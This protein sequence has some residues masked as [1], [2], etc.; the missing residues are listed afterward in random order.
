MKKVGTKSIIPVYGNFRPLER[1]CN[2]K[3]ISGWKTETKTGEKLT[4]TDTYN[5][6]A[7]VVVKGNSIQISEWHKAEAQSTQSNPMINRVPEHGRK[8]EGWTAYQGASVT[9]TQNISVSEWGTDE[10]TRIQIT[11]GTDTTK[12]YY[13]ISAVIWGSPLSAG[14]KTQIL[15]DVKN[16][17]TA[18]VR[19]ACNLGNTATVN[20]G[21]TKSVTVNGTGNGSSHWMFSFQALS[22]S[23]N[24][25]FI[26]YN[27]RAY[28]LDEIPLPDNPFP[29]QT[30]IQAGTYKTQDHKGDWYEFS[31]RE[32]LHGYHNEKDIIE[33]DKYSRKGYIRKYTS[34][35]VFDGT[36]S[37]VYADT[38]PYVGETTVTFGYRRYDAKTNVTVLCSHLEANTQY[39]KDLEGSWIGG[40]GYIWLRIAKNRLTGWSDELTTAQKNN[41]F[42]AWLAEQYN[43][44]TPV[45]SVYRL[46]TPTK[47]ELIFTKNN[48]S[49][50]P[51][52]PFVFLTSVPSEEYPASVFDASGNITSMGHNLFDFIKPPIR[53]VTLTHELIPGGV[54][55]TKN[56]T[57]WQNVYWSIPKTLAGK[58]VTIVFDAD[59]EVSMSQNY[60]RLRWGNDLT[61][62]ESAGTSYN[63]KYGKNVCV[64]S[65]PTTVSD[66]DYF[67][68]HI[69][70]QQNKDGSL[71]LTKMMVLEG[72][73]ATQNLPQYVP[74]FGEPV[75]IGLPALR[76]VGEI[77]DEYNLKS[78]QVIRRIGYIES[79]N[80]EDVTTEYISS[81]GGLDT[82]AEIRYVLP[83]PITEQLEPK[84]LPTFAKITVIETICDTVA[85]PTTQATVKVFER[86][87]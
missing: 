23:D 76:K 32:D 30:T 20:P 15:I 40:A 17:G 54:K 60:V 85:T 52:F 6:F 29:I 14:R 44:G 5:D 22:A 46:E 8:F 26:A 51:V 68:F 65:V 81:T 31:L 61:N 70:R 3:R 72:N 43:N 73:Y 41:L 24:L 21:E 11:G 19:I 53:L 16:I 49:T 78:G 18:P 34:T 33:F 69:Q 28:I 48:S 4:F 59:D 74:Y 7:D 58:D 42:K 77:A 80:G 2:N 79:Y 71:Y 35:V 82:G 1:R 13:S 37:I 62:L 87:E 25:D 10:A 56:G 27:P 12:Y 50:A 84:T 47:T 45:V 9:L 83:E 57:G 63:M 64:F 67:C 75:A 38:S 55:I 39:D 36:E 86:K 66:Y